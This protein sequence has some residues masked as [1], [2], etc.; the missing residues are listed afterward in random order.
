MGIVSGA[1]LF[2]KDKFQLRIDCGICCGSEG[3]TTGGFSVEQS[4][5]DFMIGISA[6][7][8]TTVSI[9]TLVLV[10]RLFKMH[11]VKDANGRYAWM[12]PQGW[13]ELQTK[14]NDSQERIVSAIAELSVYNVQSAKLLESLTNAVLDMRQ[15]INSQKEKPKDN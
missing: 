7:V 1:F 4:I 2:R 15:E 12:Q 14:L 3:Q 5:F 13:C 10:A 11:D 9:V 6:F 8:S